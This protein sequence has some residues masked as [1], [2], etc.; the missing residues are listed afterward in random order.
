MHAIMVLAGISK[1]ACAWAEVPKKMEAYLS[2]GFF[3]SPRLSPA[4]TSVLL[5]LLLA[6]IV[7]VSHS[8]KLSASKSFAF[9]P[10]IDPD[11]VGFPVNYFYIQAVDSGG[12][13]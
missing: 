11:R 9:G 6:L 3:P 7:P 4:S 8:A 5:C 13:K 10:G 2:A 1:T 12:E